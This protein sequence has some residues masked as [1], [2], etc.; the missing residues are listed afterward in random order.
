MNNILQLKGRFEQKKSSGRP[1]PA[2]IPVDKKIETQRIKNLRED[3]LKV[4]EFWKNE[5]LNIQ[6]LV[7]AYC[8]DVLA[9]SNRIIGMFKSN[10]KDNNACIVGAK[11]TKGE[12]KKHI[13]T[14]RVKQKD[15][16]DAINNLTLIFELCTKEFGK[17]ITYKNIEDINSKKY[18][19]L[20]KKISR[21]RFVNMLVDVYHVEKFGVEKIEESLD[22]EGIITI[23][24]T[25]KEISE[26]MKQLEID[27]EKEKALDK[28]T[29]FLYPDQYKK[30]KQKAP[31][32]I[33]MALQDLSVVEKED[34]FGSEKIFEDYKREIPSPRG[35][36]TIGVID[37]LFSDG[38]YF[39]EWVEAHN[40]VSKDIIESEDYKHGTA[41][42]SIIVDGPSLNPELEDNCGRFKVRHFGIAKA[43]TTSSFTVVKAIK[44]IVETNSD[45]RVW[46]ISL[47]SEAE[48]HPNFISPEAAI[49]D[50]LQ[51][52]KDVIFVVSGT[53]KK[54]NEKMKNIGSPADSIN[55]I[56]VNSVD[57]EN[58]PAPYSRRGEVLSFFKKPDVSYYGGSSKKQI[59][60]CC[61]D[62]ERFISGTSFAAPWITRKIAYLIEVLGLTRE[63]AK[64]LLIDSATTWEDSEKEEMIFIGYG[65]IPIDIYDIVESKNDEIKFVI[66]GI[67]D[68]YE[69]YNYNLPVPKIG[70]KQPFIAKA[71]LC[72][73]P[74]CC[75][76]QGV[77][78]T[79]T[80]MD[81]HFGRLIKTKTGMRVDSINE[82]RQAEDTKL[83]LYEAE[84]RKIYRKWD[85]VKHIREYLH[86]PTGRLK[87]PKKAKDNSLWGINIKKKERLNAEDGKGLKFGMVITLK[88]VNGENRIE[89]FI[90]ECQFRGWIVNRIDVKNRIEI[91]NKAEEEIVFE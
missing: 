47:G 27:F 35:E 40:M 86:T 6:P 31:Y 87:K 18:E 43:T 83:K 39:S 36:P 13:I 62:G 65:V 77:D 41:V 76:N 20:F 22:R 73:F 14:Y 88:E 52:E 2:N 12:L 16:K 78:Y 32:L 75:R 74:K 46:N 50:E 72:Y 38:V 66:N 60:V 26:V 51:Y 57:W 5:K 28:T 19:K 53:N 90:Q 81:I 58:N 7:T 34:I 80:E 49:L 8:P 69:T 82:N 10:L 42:S 54:L 9:K 84:A 85:N 91:Y 11:F 44:K 64:A 21:S 4:S 67:A 3:L 89:H 55:S 71:T 17:E 68:K 24:D 61:P 37:T 33:S 15:I 45:I 70:K 63:V 59:K 79:N 25:G 29:L 30:L 56:V 48:I 23:Y 1:G